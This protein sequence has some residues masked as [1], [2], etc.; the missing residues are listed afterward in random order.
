VFVGTHPSYPPVTRREPDR[1][2]RLQVLSASSGT[3]A[4]R[5]DAFTLWRERSTRAWTLDLSML[6]TAGM[7][8]APPPGSSNRGHIAERTLR[9]LHRPS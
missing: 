9:D 7:T 5:S 3:L 4:Y 1:G 8:L 6:T 2:A